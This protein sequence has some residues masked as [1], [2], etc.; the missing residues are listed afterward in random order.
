MVRRSIAGKIKYFICISYIGW[1]LLT[2]IYATYVPEPVFQQA[3][4]FCI[5]DDFLE[6]GKSVVSKPNTADKVFDNFKG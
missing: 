1:F 2:D 4:R 5:Y 6:Q 3:V